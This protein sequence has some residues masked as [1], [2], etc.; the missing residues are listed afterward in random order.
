[1][2][3]PQEKHGGVPSTRTDHYGGHLEGGE[4]NGIPGTCTSVVAF[5]LLYWV[6]YKELYWRTGCCTCSSTAIY[7]AVLVYW[8]LYC[9]AREG[10]ATSRDPTT[11][12]SEHI[13]C[14]PNVPNVLD[15]RTPWNGRP[16]V[17]S[18]I[19]I[20]FD[21]LLRSIAKEARWVLCFGGSRTSSGY[22]KDVGMS[23]GEQ[24]VNRNRTD[25]SCN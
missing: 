4:M 7:T 21:R 19:G 9:W 1:M 22:G 25:V 6:L 14:I 5:V 18:N 15:R 11:V 3:S 24:M 10:A 8:P 20:R 13:H 2:A 16:L 12:L 23:Y 17:F